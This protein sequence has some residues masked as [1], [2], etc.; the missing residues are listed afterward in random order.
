MQLR[1]GREFTAGELREDQYESR[2]IYIYKIVPLA[3]GLNLVIDITRKKKPSAL[4]RD[5]RGKYIVRQ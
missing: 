3:S 5:R 4:Q 2:R 1:N